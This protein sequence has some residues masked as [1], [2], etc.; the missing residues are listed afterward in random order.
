MTVVDDPCIPVEPMHPQVVI[1]DNNDRPVEV[2][3]GLE[4]LL[5]MMWQISI[6]TIYSCQ[7]ESDLEDPLDLVNRIERGYILMERNWASDAFV[8]ELVRDLDNIYP[9]RK[10]ALDIEFDY[11]EKFGPRICLRFPHQDIQKFCDH[12][13]RTYF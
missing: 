5:A 6:R 13:E 2:D 1:F 11:H 12:V 8:R 3:E 9:N 4:K 10:M 7:G